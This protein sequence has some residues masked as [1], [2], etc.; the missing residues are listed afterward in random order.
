MSYVN[1]IEQ[2]VIPALQRFGPDLIIIACGLDASGV[3]PL[4]RMM[5]SS[6][7]FRAMTRMVREAAETLSGGRLVAVHEGGYSEVAVPFCGL[8]VVEELASHRTAVE[9]PFLPLLTLQQPP[10]EFDRLEASRLHDLR[11]LYGL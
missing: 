7:T 8:A 6:E 10:P 1:A 4:A 11:Q 5:A 3:D 9:D 2:I